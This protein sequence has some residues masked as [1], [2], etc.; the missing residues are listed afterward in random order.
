MYVYVEPVAV[1]P[2]SPRALYASFPSIHEARGVAEIVSCVVSF[3][4]CL[5]GSRDGLVALVPD[6]TE[7]RCPLPWAEHSPD[8]A[9]RVAVFF[10]LVDACVEL[11][12]HLSG[13]VC[14]HGPRQLR[15]V[16][17]PFPLSESARHLGR[18]NPRKYRGV[19]NKKVWL[20]TGKNSD[21]KSGRDVLVFFA[22]FGSIASVQ[23]WDSKVIFFWRVDIIEQYNRGYSSTSHSAQ[24]YAFGDVSSG[25]KLLSGGNE[26]VVHV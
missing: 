22:R 19:Q 21:E 2:S 12:A 20:G 11:N 13:R 7:I 24:V 8:R 10:V 25:Q 23:C 17:H 26:C 18:R 6:T 15:P 1:V 16:A 14:L 4:L 5:Q 9:R 3:F